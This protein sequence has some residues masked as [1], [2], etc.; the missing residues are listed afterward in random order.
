MPKLSK[1]FIDAA[2]PEAKRRFLWDDNL[3]GF[4][5]LVLPSGRKS[6]V[7]QYR[8]LAGRSRRLTLGQYGA[9][10]PSEAKHMAADALA[11]IWKGEDPLAARHA[12]RA[13]PTINDLMDR[14]LSDHV[15][16]HNAK[17]TQAG[18]KSAIKSVIKPHLG[19]VKLSDISRRDIAEL[20]AKLSKTPRQAN[21]VLAVL[22]KA[23]NLAEV[24]GWRPEQSNPV[25]LIK[26]YRENERDRFLSDVELV[27]LGKTLDEAERIGLP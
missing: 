8:T 3:K 13:A 27:R 20:H 23:F 11:K 19:T 9:L 12:L 2:K 7:L 17:S 10:T 14:Y 22:S 21:R 6:F 5:L 25:R 1:R 24:W 18:V 4:G 16:V 26:R 15:L